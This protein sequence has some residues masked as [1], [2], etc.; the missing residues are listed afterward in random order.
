MSARYFH[1][2]LNPRK[3]IDIGFSH[4]PYDMT[5]EQ[6]VR[7]LRLPKK[8]LLGMKPMEKTHIP[9]AMDL[10]NKYLA[11]DTDLTTVFTSQEEFS[12][13]FSPVP[14]VIWSYVLEVTFHVIK[15]AEFGIQSCRLHFFLCS[16]K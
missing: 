7:R 8:T 13:W 16:A 15:V 1:R 5:M 11:K 6:Y 3:L 9:Q 10:L 12:H 4:I 14:N 2:S